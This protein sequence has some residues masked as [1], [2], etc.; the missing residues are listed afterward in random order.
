MSK[1]DPALD[2]LCVNTI[3][4]L[5]IDAILKAN[6]GHPGL[7]LGAAPA[8]WALWSRHLR[9]NPKN[10]GWVDRDRFVLSAGHGSMLL[11][12]LLHLTGYDLPLDEI[13]SFRQ[14]GSRTPGHPEH[15]LTSGVETT[16]GP[17]GQG[18]ANSV[19]LAMAEAHLGARFNRPGHT[20]VDHHTYVLAGDGDLM[21][22]VT[23]EAMSLAGHLRLGKLVC[24]YDANR[25]SLAGATDLSFTQD[26][27]RTFEAAGW[28]VL[29]V[30]DGNDLDGLDAALAA[31]KSQARWPSLIVVR[32][33]IGF[34]S[35]KQ[36][37]FGVH[38]APL[39]AEE[40]VQTKKALGYPSEE[41]FFIPEESL[42]EM[43]TA[44]G[45][46]ARREE[47]WRD[48][49]EAYRKA[50]P[51]LAADFERALAGELP[52]GW[53]ADIPRFSAGDKPLATRSAGGKV[54]N[55]I[56]ARVP[57]LLG[58]SADLN[59]STNTA[60]KGAGDFQSP[61]REGDRQG[62]VG[63]SWGYAGR[64]IHFGVRE[65]AM[66]GIA[67]GLALHGGLRPFTATFLMFADYMRGAIRLGA[68]MELPVTY[69]FTHD[70]IAVGEDGP[71][72]EPVEHAAALRAIPRLTVLRPAD[73]NETAAAWRFAMTHTQGPVV[74]LLTRQAVPIL[75][76]PA[77]V[78]RG[79]YVLADAE[80]TPELVLIASGSEVSLALEVRDIIGAGRIRV[81]SMPSPDLFLKQD[82]AYQ[83]SV[84]PPTVWARMAVEAGV[85]QGW[86]R[87]VGPLGEVVAI[88]N[89]FGTSA[90]GK[91]AMEKYG[92]TAAQVAE[93]A[94][95]LLAAFPS[96][97]KEMAAALADH[98]QASS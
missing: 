85:P 83:D 33:N 86:H 22:G 5:S 28:H 42:A 7:P 80:G 1:P 10:P 98:R 26:M 95:A 93:R 24:L 51:E 11:Y 38:G 68:L 36:D 84:L 37:T 41:P 44:V 48:R 53:D 73:A 57:E 55:A 39:N 91:V 64:N 77:E 59:P 20:I 88:E 34:G 27:G 70:S 58:G 90:P 81:V 94:R 76:G 56:A 46:G 82:Q 49:F 12:S 29:H 14:W 52:E 23:L 21:E 60:L 40:I 96:R 71:T 69:V 78:A 47:D 17:L 30:D 63:E 67:S 4:A 66:G 18:F 54:M 15:G 62:A 72:H 35:P 89:R 25:I 87:F 2:Q 16:T 92:F 50:H 19:G 75:D 97:A 8:A 31:A 6:S 3:R 43:R 32:S 13:K 74:L 45:D 65:H 61:S 79:G 9:H